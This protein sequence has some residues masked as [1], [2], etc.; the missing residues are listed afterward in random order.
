MGTSDAK[1]SKDSW[2][3]PV[4]QVLFFTCFYLYVWLAV[5]PYL[6]YHA[7]GI[8]MRF[9]RFSVDWMFFK[10]TVSW[11]GGL[12]EY[13]GA[14]LSQLYYFPWAGALI[15]TIVCLCICWCTEKLI[16]LAGAGQSKVLCYLPV[17][18]ILM[19]YIRYDNP[20]NICLALLAGLCFSVLYQ[21]LSIQSGSRRAAVFF[22]MCIVLYYVA[23]GASLVFVVLAGVYD[24]FVRRQLVL[25]MFFLLIGST[26]PA[27]FGIG[28]FGQEVT[29]AYLVLTPFHPEM[30]DFL[31]EGY[32]DVLGKCLYL[33]FPVVMFFAVLR[34]KIV[35]LKFD[36]KILFGSKSKLKPVV[37]T[38]IL[39][40]ISVSS[41]HFSFDYARK[42]LVQ[43]TC[44]SH[45]KMWPELLEYARKIPSN[46]YSAYCGHEVNRALYYTGRLGDEMFSFPQ[47][48]HTL[49]LFG[50][51]LGY[52]PVKFMKR[53]ESCLELGGVNR[54]ERESHEFLEAQGYNPFILKRLAKI[55]IIKG[56]DETASVF[57]NALS[58]DLIH[59]RD[60]EDILQQLEDGKFDNDEEIKRLRSI[61]IT[62]DYC[63]NIDDY[64]ED[65]LLEGLLES[66]RNNRMA[67]EYLM[68][69]YLLTAQ[70]DKFVK[71]IDRLD[72]FGYETIPLHYE[73]ALVMYMGS[74]KKVNLNGRQ[75]RPETIA[76]SR[77][78]ISTYKRLG[79]DRQAAFN[80]LAYDYGQ[81]YFLYYMF[82]TS[83]VRR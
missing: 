34:H 66:N 15:I 70:L 37:Q 1:A 71:N 42:S 5:N 11:P 61:M 43:I 46:Y 76:R 17:L 30:N 73:E 35:W 40:A 31:R 54:S 75:I 55:N 23:G 51:A 7:F 82:R 27:L 50:Q 8:F 47:A 19:M 81:S 33:F 12:V 22:V 6:V 26:V 79:R 2:N 62:K 67:F 64:N 53:S 28:I 13:V 83:G 38:L 36:E 72:D 57:L 39:V 68:A 80:A 32:V 25:G 63:I 4:R 45:Q 56:Q 14:F 69:Y 24:I 74:G 48:P 77:K 41:V 21:G 52:N 44:F 59:S 3:F 10:E 78:F 18:L 49:L 60:A 16:K 58:T 29:D 9:P 65:I 20:L